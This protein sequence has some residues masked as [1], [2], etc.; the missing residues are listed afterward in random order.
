MTVRPEDWEVL[1]LEPGADITRVKQA[2]R[3]RRS[4][5]E[6]TSLATYSLLDDDERETM[7]G[8]I[9][10]AYHR[11]VGAAPSPAT[12]PNAA[13]PPAAAVEVPTG[14]VPD[15]VR[16]P[17]AHLRHRRLSRGLT[18]QRIAAETKIAVSILEQ[19]ENE[20]FD[21]LPAAVFVRGHVQQYAREIRLEDVEEMASNYI[22]KMQGDFDEA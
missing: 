18:L 11:I 3:H 5:Y 9:D 12:I 7:I 15:P 16:E 13:E 19:I 17:G 2:H 10:E 20:N 21:G 6:P 14:P 4:L 1:G 8:R 22:A